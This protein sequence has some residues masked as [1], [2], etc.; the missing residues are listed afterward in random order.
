M[1]VSLLVLYVML[2]IVAFCCGVMFN[3]RNDED[4]RADNATFAMLVGAMLTFVIVGYSA[5]YFLAYR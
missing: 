2:L 4:I 1:S 3:A 5:A